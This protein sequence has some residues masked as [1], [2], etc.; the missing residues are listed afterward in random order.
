MFIEILENTGLIN[1]KRKITKIGGEDKEK[2]VVTTLADSGHKWLYLIGDELT[3][4]RLKSF[5]N[6][7]NDSLYSFEDDYEM[8]QVLYLAL[9]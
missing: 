5:V 4:V 2:L 1:I 7:I 9:K 6:V 3:H 8:R